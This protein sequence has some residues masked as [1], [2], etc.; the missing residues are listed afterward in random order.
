MN[1]KGFLL[2]EGD[3]G[4]KEDY[5]CVGRSICKGLRRGE[6][7]GGEGG[8]FL[9]GRVGEGKGR[10]DV[11]GEEGHFDIGMGRCA[12]GEGKRWDES[13]GDGK[14]WRYKMGMRVSTL[15]GPGTRIRSLSHI[16]GSEGRSGV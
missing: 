15:W 5:R 9:D 7:R 10:L 2:V 3:E 8:M 16:V 11:K 1:P 6:G 4:V 12:A 14:R 13:G